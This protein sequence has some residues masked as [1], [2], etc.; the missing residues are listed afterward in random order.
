MELVVVFYLPGL[1][2]AFPDANHRGVSPKCLERIKL[3]SFTVEHVYDHV[4]VIDQNPLAA[5]L[6]FD[7]PRSQTL[8]GE[9]V[10]D[11]IGDRQDLRLGVGGKNHEPIDRRGELAEI[12]KDDVVGFLIKREGAGAFGQLLRRQISGAL[13]R[14][15]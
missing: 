4:H 3:S 12:E 7:V 11:V 15:Q 8:A 5:L 1:L 9:G 2:G 13:L 14:L 10:H 6:T